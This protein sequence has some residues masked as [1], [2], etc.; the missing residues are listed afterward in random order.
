[1]TSPCRH[2]PQTACISVAQYS[3]CFEC[4]SFVLSDAFSGRRDIPK[5]TPRLCWSQLWITEANRH[6]YPPQG[7]VQI[8]QK[9]CWCS[10]RSIRT[11]TLALTFQHPPDKQ[12]FL[13]TLEKRDCITWHAL[14]QFPMEICNLVQ[15]YMCRDPTPLETVRKR[16][17]KWKQIENPRGVLGK[18]KK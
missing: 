18:R 14:L 15:A 17:A 13:Q 5:T 2:C 1:M 16:L 10:L 6:L 7:E 11:K 3:F 8:L 12:C 4:V 9:D